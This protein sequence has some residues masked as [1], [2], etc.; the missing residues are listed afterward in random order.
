MAFRWEASNCGIVTGLFHGID[1]WQRGRLHSRGLMHGV[2]CN[3]A[4]AAE[5][6]EVAEEGLQRMHCRGG[7]AEVA[8]QRRSLKP[9]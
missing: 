5:D 7:V 6:A 2:R 3:F 4:E 1:T 9:H 8:R